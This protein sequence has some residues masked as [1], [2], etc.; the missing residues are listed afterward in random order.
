MTFHTVTRLPGMPSESA[1]GPR[2]PEPLGR[3]LP[4]DADAGQ[5]ADAVDAV[6]RDID[7]ALHPILGHRGVLAL[8]N[9]SLALAAVRHPWLAAGHP[10]AL[11]AIDASA[12]RAALVQQAPAEAAAGGSALLQRFRDLLSSLVGASLTDRL[13]R[14]VWAPTP[15]ASPLEDASPP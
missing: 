5:V 6:W 4:A 8:Y 2:W 9:R 15:G 7:Q 12:L 14:P 3:R 13:L 1:Q 11:A 10:G